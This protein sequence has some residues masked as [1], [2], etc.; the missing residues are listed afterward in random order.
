MIFKDN[1][2]RFS[3]NEST[4]SDIFH[5]LMEADDSFLSKLSLEVDLIEYSDKLYNR[6]IRFECWSLNNLIGLIAM[7][8]N[9]EGTP[10]GYITSV[11][12][13]DAFTRKGIANKLMSDA[14]E[15]AKDINIGHI[16]LHVYSYNSKAIKFYTNCGFEVI[17]SKNSKTLMSLFLKFSKK[18]ES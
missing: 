3:K 6:A 4:S 13:L 12:V 11:S 5:H 15:Y 8:E 18:I 9:F 7:Y 14:I 16:D 17:E 2:F 1:I 10:F